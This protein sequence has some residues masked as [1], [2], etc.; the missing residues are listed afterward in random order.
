MPLSTGLL[1]VVDVDFTRLLHGA[2]HGYFSSIGEELYVTESNVEET[3]EL[4]RVA[5]ICPTFIKLQLAF[6]VF[7]DC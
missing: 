3:A 6:A 1:L 7:L 2:V 4:P 5:L